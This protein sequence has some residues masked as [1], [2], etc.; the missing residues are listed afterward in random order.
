MGDAI[1][2]AREGVHVCMVYVAMLKEEGFIDLST[3]E[4]GYCMLRFETK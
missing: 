1:T 4:T 3:G 2:S